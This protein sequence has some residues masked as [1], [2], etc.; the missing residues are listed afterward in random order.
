M[1]VLGTLEGG[2]SPGHMVGDGSQEAVGAHS[3]Q[4]KSD[5][6][7]LQASKSLLLESQE[8]VYML[9]LLPPL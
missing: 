2:V 9:E 7:A 6:V 1:E 8:L 3:Q 4:Y 5:Q